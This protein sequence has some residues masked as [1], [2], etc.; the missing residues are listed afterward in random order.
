MEHDHSAQV[1]PVQHQVYLCE[2]AVA[3]KQLRQVRLCRSVRQVAH[4]QPPALRHARALVV[5]G[6][7][8][9][10]NRRGARRALA[11]VRPGDVRTR[12]RVHLNAYV[13]ARIDARVC[14]SFGGLAPRHTLGLQPCC[15]G[16]SASRR[17]R[18]AAPCTAATS[19]SA[20]PLVLVLVL[21]VRPFPRN[22]L[23]PQV[24]KVRH[25]IVACIRRGW[26]AASAAAVF[27]VVTVHGAAAV[28]RCAI[29]VAPAAAA[30]GNAEPTGGRLCPAT[31]HLI[32]V[33]VLILC[34]AANVD[35]NARTRRACGV[36]LR[37]RQWRRRRERVVIGPRLGLAARRH[38]LEELCKFWVV[39]ARM[40]RGGH[41][42]VGHLP[43]SG[44]NDRQLLPIHTFQQLL[45][46]TN[47][48]CHLPATCGTAEWLQGSAVLY[49]WK[50]NYWDYKHRRAPAPTSGSLQIPA[51]IW[52]PPDTCQHLAASRYLPTS[53]SLQEA[54]QTRHP[55]TA[56]RH[57][58]RARRPEHQ[59][60]ARRRGQATLARQASTATRQG[61]PGQ[62]SLHHNSARQAG[63]TTQPG[64]PALKFSEA[65]RAHL[66]PARRPR[67]PSSCV[68]ARLRCAPLRRRPPRVAPW[69]PPV[70]GRAQSCRP[71][72][73]SKG[74]GC[75][76]RHTCVQTAS[77]GGKQG[78]YWMKAGGLPSMTPPAATP[79][80]WGG[81]RA[82]C[83]L[84]RG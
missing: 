53:G 9:D 51:N 28:I 3:S 27:V 45:P 64:N 1:S 42:P 40:G 26:P 75:P 65:S 15:S 47:N 58:N 12:A 36:R 39:C 81:S 5:V 20:P 67:R 34:V 7:G 44:N 68:S 57:R 37:P 16:D 24:L 29:R 69:L 8:H 80:A 38:E 19:A 61:E 2:V 66:L 21:A 41:R 55:D 73:G 84:S 46:P 11:C 63:T 49:N 18:P 25:F 6:L 83:G 72:V 76:G 17:A 50:K 74:E 54:N 14:M 82:D 56:T 59:Y 43:I 30:A 70:R 10:L 78:G 33:L 52:Q 77:C 79:R 60:L 48:C 23:R 35:A 32:H 4:K 71:S 62:A 13:R 31:R 22:H